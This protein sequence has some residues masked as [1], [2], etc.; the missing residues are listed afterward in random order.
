MSADS[1]VLERDVSTVARG[2]EEK[3][4]LPATFTDGREVLRAALAHGLN[5]LFYPRQ[6]MM[7]GAQEGPEATV[8]FVHGI[9]QGFTYAQDRRVRRALIERARLP[10][11]RGATFSYRGVEDSRR[12]A[13]R[14]GFPLSLKEA[15]G[16]NPGEQISGIASIG[17]LDAA[18]QQLRELPGKRSAAASSVDRS[19]YA[20]T[21]LL[22]LHEDEDGRKLAA[23]ATRFLIERETEGQYLRFFVLD[24]KVETILLCH[25]GAPHRMTGNGGPAGRL[26]VVTMSKPRWRLGGSVSEAVHPEYGERALEAVRA[27]PGLAMAMVDIV[28]RDYH[29]APASGSYVIADLGERLR[30]DVLDAVDPAL[31]SSLADRILAYEARRVGTPLKPRSDTV[32]LRVRVESVA[33]PEGFATLATEAVSAFGLEGGFSVDDPIDGILGGTLEGKAGDVARLA[34][35]MMAGGLG[36][37]FPRLLEITHKTG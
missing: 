28:T 22:D 20:L 30:L 5:V 37:Q 33:D 15:V 27:V 9:P 19:A 24:G 23:P 14:L 10:I 11:P 12:Y 13:R 4:E 16:E 6:V 32:V 31:G 1:G 34:E 36:G 21:A 2:D 17:E 35:V 18:I 25:G 8:C 7:A 29:R 3:F 26:E